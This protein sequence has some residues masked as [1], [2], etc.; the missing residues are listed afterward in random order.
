MK[1]FFSKYRSILLV[2]ALLLLFL[3]F[4]NSHSL[5]QQ[6]SDQPSFGIGL[7]FGHWIPSRLAGDDRLTSLKKASE[8]PYLGIVIVKPWRSLALRFNA[9]YWE[10]STDKNEEQFQIGTIGADVKYFVLTDVWFVPYMIYGIGWFLGNERTKNSSSLDFLNNPEIGLGFNLGAGFDFMVRPFNFVIEFKYHYVTFNKAIGST[11]NF[12][13]P[14]I[15]VQ[16]IY[17]FRY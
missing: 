10:Y 4:P 15:G 13:G 12:S 6:K 14:Q 16:A 1:D 9:G 8:N 7:E 2:F 17:F 11:H 5:A 3:I